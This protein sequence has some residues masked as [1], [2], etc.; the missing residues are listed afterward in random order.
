M[1]IPIAIIGVS[2]L[3][4]GGS[5]S[6]E[7][8]RNILVG[9]DL[10]GE[11]PGDR[12]LA[13]DYG[14][15]IDAR[16]GGFIDEVDFDPLEFGIP[17]EN[18]SATDA[19]QLLAL[20]AAKRLF[21]DLG[22]PGLETVDRERTGVIL[23][24]A[25]AT[26]LA[27]HTAGKLQEP[28]LKEA[29]RRVGLDGEAIE[30]V[31]DEFSKMYVPFQ[32]NTFPGLLA[33]VVAGR[34]ANRFD[35]GGTNRVVDAACASSLAALEAGVDQLRG[36]R[37]ELMI[38]GG[39]DLLTDAVLHACF[40][41][42]GA[43]SKS[44]RCR[45]FDKNADGTLLGEGLGLFALKRLDDAEAQGDSIYAVIGGIGSSSDGRAKSI[46]APRAAGQARAI[47]R[48]Y[49]DAGYEPRTVEL[50]EAH[51]TAT[52]AGDGAELEAL[53]QV[54]GDEGG[55]S[56]C[57][58]GS[59]K[60]QIGHTRAAAG[61]AGLFKAI[62]AL[63]DRVLPPTAGVDEPNQAL[64]NSP[65]Y[66]NTEVRP[67]FRSSKRPRRAGV[68]A[69][70]F[71]GT[72]FH[73][74]VQEYS[75]PHRAPR[76]RSLPHELF[77][78]SADEAGRLADLC[79]DLQEH[80][81]VRS[82]AGHAA[83]SQRRFDAS[84]KYRLAIVASD[85]G[86][87]S[88][89]LG[90]AEEN[91]RSAPET[92]FSTPSGV[93]YDSNETP[94][95]VAFLF[96]GQGSQYVGMGRE[97]AVYFE[98]A[99][100]V[101][102]ASEELCGVVFP[103][104]T[105]STTER[106]A[107]QDRLTA[108]ENAQPAIGAMS[109][110]I[111]TLL[112]EMGLS[113]KFAAGHSYGEVTALF[114][115]RA[116]SLANL[117]EISKKR[118]QLMARAGN[119]PGAMTAVAAGVDDA[120]RWIDQWELDLV[121]ANH[122]APKQVVLSGPT[123]AVERAEKKLRAQAT[124]FKRLPVSTAFHS[125]LV[126]D[127]SEP[128]GE[129]LDGLDLDA[130]TISVFA[131]ATASPY[132][133]NLDSIRDELAGQLSNPVRFVDMVRAMHDEGARIFVEVG[134][135]STLTNLVGKCLDERPHRAIP[136]D[137]R[138][139]SGI[140][141]FFNGLARLSA[142]GVELDFQPLWRGYEDL[143]AEPVNE[144]AEHAVKIGATIFKKPYPSDNPRPAPRRISS[145]PRDAMSHDE[146]SDRAQLL[147]ALREQQRQTAEAHRIFQETTAAA[148]RD[149]L[150]TMEAS[151][152]SIKYL[153]GDA[154]TPAP[155]ALT[156][157][158]HKNDALQ[159]EF[160]AP[161]EPG[162]ESNIG[163]L[164]LEVVAEKT[165]YPAKM[166]KLEME[167]EADLGVDSIKQVEIL[168]A[169]EDQLPGLPELEPTEVAE[170]KS[171]GR[172]AAHIEGLLGGRAPRRVGTDD[173]SD[174][175]DDSESD[176]GGAA[177][178]RF[179]VEDRPAP[180]CGWGMVGLNGD[181][182]ILVIG[183]QKK[184]G[185]ALMEL[186]DGS[187]DP[188]AFASLRHLPIRNTHG[189]DQVGYPRSEFSVVD[190]FAEV[191]THLITIEDHRHDPW[192][193]LSGFAKTAAAEWPDCAV[194]SIN[195]PLA[196]LGDDR[197]AQLIF[198]EITTGGP[199]LEVNFDDQ[200]RRYVPVTI[201]GSTSGTTKILEPGD[202]V[203]VS[204]GA[205]GITAECVVALAE[206]IPLHFVLLGRT[207][208]REIP[209]GLAG[210]SGRALRQALLEQSKDKLTP[211]QLDRRARTIEARREIADTLRR[212]EDTGATAVYHSVDVRDIDA[213]TRIVDETRNSTGSIRGI[214]HGAG[215]IDDGLIV[216]KTAEQFDRVFGTKVDG[217]RSL[218]SATADDDL[219]LICLFSSV[220]A[221]SG[222]PGQS[223]Y[224]MANEVLN[225]VAHSLARERP[226]CRVKAI[227]WGPW[228]GGMVDETL[229]ARFLSQGVPLIP[230]KVGAKHFVDEVLTDSGDV[231]VI[232][233]G[234]VFAEGFQSLQIPKKLRAQ[235]EI[236]RS[237]HPYLDGHRIRGKV[238][239]PAMVVLEWFCRFAKATRPD[240]AIRE[241]RDFRV[242]KGITVDDF[243]DVG[244][245]VV[246][247]G[248]FVDDRSLKIEI[249][250]GDRLHYRGLVELGQAK[251]EGKISLSLLSSALK[252]I[253]TYGGDVD[254]LSERLFH[255]GPFLVL[256]EYRLDDDRAFA[257]VK[258]LRQMDWS[259]ED[260]QIDPAALDGALQL[261]LLWSYELI[262]KPTIIMGVGKFANF[263]DGP[264]DTSLHCRANLQ[265]RTSRRMIVDIEVVDDDGRARYV[266]TDVEMYALF[267]DL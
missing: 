40:S 195:L 92:P 89:K 121:V 88:D 229:A 245:K 188:S 246:I 182:E 116:F 57:A 233:G 85:K 187:I 58:L 94:G 210:L 228:E 267:E 252:N 149:F 87:L 3:F 191:P 27:F 100:Q 138:G 261:C 19:G 207:E 59:I 81:E 192:T 154:P 137:R 97:L 84:Q 72:N 103:P 222:N 143:I 8:W 38:T 50:V 173:R 147:K 153:G 5:S 168:S 6:R 158:L 212:L 130:P 198:D 18:L 211:R 249:V 181:C 41:R 117:L 264:V 78:F 20:V 213:L 110:S 44:G 11:I 220:A 70:G 236:N 170:L 257:A 251:S 209:K 203:I 180:A 90:A 132:D 200:G 163:A 190:E 53:Q 65:F 48:A 166:L 37:A 98:E 23:G 131:N 83:L 256:E 201:E 165:G 127:S 148:H 265:S 86:D 241:V 141:S 32:E 107:Q 7:F 68:S 102:E 28:I 128:F 253:E 189:E 66:L 258:G 45:P 101:W 126:A 77:V 55:E 160:A 13:A 67:W 174:S 244:T 25:A 223:D 259:D 12:W 263:A 109:A 159:D 42:V 186:F 79:D 61:A 30:A 152:E 221:R 225:H 248:E 39:V 235:I 17:P 21:K 183:G 115:G 215:V 93:H 112:E 196:A 60:S 167:I 142:L 113:A 46:Y 135:G 206:E 10:M 14:D 162:G 247:G 15:A 230:I 202:T 193:G 136:L 177:I 260:W 34:V 205:R 91:I 169:L 99:R 262:G 76:R 178:S 104:P 124:P 216:D 54:F 71:G 56:Y 175:E 226:N 69:S 156:S 122:N 36:G 133:G 161:P 96:P 43:L 237:N 118:G 239:V 231:E 243:E 232:V 9:A 80:L 64:A 184:L 31:A 24:V 250:D 185:E 172:I 155:R 164:L 29:M 26:E 176:P 2:A 214:V 95:D 151:F 49:D 144:V 157:E 16:R 255:S 146:G 139:Q 197:A 242:L 140:E 227:G 51:G 208:R 82:F 171:L 119:S 194:K 224:A 219:R 114:A 106:A 150:R 63:N 125:P 108:T 234:S 111:L 74:T 47:E 179:V 62:M 145:T 35:L 73:V 199:A 123:D 254:A 105:F 1:D 218:L 75:G 134:P 129:F 33:N 217:L 266:L 240:L 238:V 120:A 204:G 52:A 22:D 4:P